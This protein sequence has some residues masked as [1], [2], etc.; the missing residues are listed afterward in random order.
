MMRQSN[1]VFRLPLPGETGAGVWLLTRHA[2]VELA[3]RDRRFS[4]D[5]M[6]AD[7]AR[8]NPERM[9]DVFLSGPGGLRTMLVMDPPDHTRVRGLVSKAFTPRRVAALER[10]RPKAR[11]RSCSTR[12]SPRGSA[13]RRDPR[14]RASRC[15]RS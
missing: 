8:L 15:P 5:R 2:E 13:L 3:L 10:A 14:P 9:P 11:R 6:R 4:V 12:R 1:P 7:A